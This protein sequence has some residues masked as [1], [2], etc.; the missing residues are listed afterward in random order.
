MTE[1]IG[2]TY[3]E[4]GG[5]H[6]YLG[7]ANLP[8]LYDAVI[9]ADP[10]PIKA[11]IV[12]A[13]NPLVSHPDTRKVYS[14]LKKLELLVVMDLCWTPAAQLADY[15]LPATSWLERPMLYSESG[16]GKVLEMIDA[17]VPAV[18]PDYDRR[19][20]YDL[21]RGLGVRTGQAASGRGKR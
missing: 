21:W 3:G 18:T 5:A 1:T 16:F 4:R 10:Y 15:V 7:Q 8:A 12:S 2:K 9:S 13:S 19:D 6:W 20:D 17:V 11:M 14:A